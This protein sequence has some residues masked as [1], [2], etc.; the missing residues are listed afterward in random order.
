MKVRLNLV[1]DDGSYIDVSDETILMQ[2]VVT[3][4]NVDPDSEMKYTF[5]KDSEGN[6]YTSLVNSQTYESITLSVESLTGGPVVSKK[7]SEPESE[8]KNADQEEAPAK[9]E[10][11]ESKTESGSGSSVGCR[12][13]SVRERHP[14]FA[15]AKGKGTTLQGSF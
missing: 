12:T 13:H 7:E 1:S 6:E 2:S 3:E 4:Q 10:E 8:G 14:S 15:S 5:D 11:A 9:S